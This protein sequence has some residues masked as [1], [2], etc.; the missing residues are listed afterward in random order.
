[1]FADLAIQEYAALIARTAVVVCNNTLPLHLADATRTPVVA[2]YS[3]TELIS[4]WGPRF[5][6]ARVLQRVTACTPCYRFSCPIGLPC[7][8][9]DPEEVVAALSELAPL[10]PAAGEPRMVVA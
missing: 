10:T 7:L 4:Q 9:F 5:T 2:L 1:V 8:D 3:G 6:P